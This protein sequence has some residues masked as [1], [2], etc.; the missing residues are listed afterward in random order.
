MHYIAYIVDHGIPGMEPGVDLLSGPYA[1]AEHARADLA[2]VAREHPA[3]VLMVLMAER[4]VEGTGEE[5]SVRLAVVTVTLPMITA[6][7][8]RH[9]TKLRAP[10]L[11]MHAERAAEIN[12]MQCMRNE[13]ERLRRKAKRDAKR[14]EREAANK[15]GM[16]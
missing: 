13:R 3:C 14:A 1:H 8:A 5:A 11:N 12:R 10:L 6:Y 16:L 4:A 9:G 15:A 2:R 7:N